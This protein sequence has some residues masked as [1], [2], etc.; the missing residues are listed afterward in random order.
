[1]WSIAFSTY[2]VSDYGQHFSED[3]STS[4]TNQLNLSSKNWSGHVSTNTR[5]GSLLVG[6]CTSHHQ[7]QHSHHQESGQD[8]EEVEQCV[9]EGE[10]DVGE[11]N[12]TDS[13]AEEQGGLAGT[14]SFFSYR[15]MTKTIQKIDTQT[16]YITWL[17]TTR[18]IIGLKVFLEMPDWDP[19][20]LATPPPSIT[21]RTLPLPRD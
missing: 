12:G 21:T 17:P 13:W 4:S 15:L 1:M 16:T 3:I 18:P 5:L 19:C 10:E 11:V 7:D 8:R 14:S 2:S 6:L 20:Q 9:E